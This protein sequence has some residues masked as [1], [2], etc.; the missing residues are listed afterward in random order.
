MS[1]LTY[2]VRNTM[3]TPHRLTIQELLMSAAGYEEEQPHQRY[4]KNFYKTRTHFVTQP[5][6]INMSTLYSL[7]DTPFTKDYIQFRIP[8]HSG[9]TRLIEA[10]T[11]ELKSLQANI[12][13][14]LLHQYRILPHNAAYAYTH[15]RSA[16]DSLVTH[17]ANNARWFLKIDV[18]DFFPTISKEILSEQLPKIYP[19]NQI[20]PTILN[21]MVDI[22]TNESGV[23]PQG[24]PLSPMLSNMVLVEFDLRLSNKLRDFNRST[25]TYTRYADDIL[26]SSPYSFKFEYIVTAIEK[27]FTELNLPFTIN[28]SK[29]R[30]A[31]KAGRNWNLGL[32]YNQDQ[33]ITVGTK[34]KK[35]LH[36]LVNSFVNEE[37]GIQET[38]ELLGKLAYLKNVEPEYHKTLIQKYERKYNV[39]IQQMFT[40]ILSN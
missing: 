24:S 37:W 21:R 16:Y 34:R 1:Y 31:S 4:S 17:Q 36:S 30:Y 12:A 40:D 14:T 23:L 25:Y 33:N 19:F 7:I 13:H 39:N 5:R 35:E 8:K 22:A 26:I 29:L 2:I 20:P 10:P 11:D 9:G 27:L 3:N 28:K 18:K 32:M 6:E 38:Q 15:G